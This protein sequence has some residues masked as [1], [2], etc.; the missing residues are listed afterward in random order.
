MIQSFL[1]CTNISFVIK[2]DFISPGPWE[3]PKLNYAVSHPR[4]MCSRG[5]SVSCLTQYLHLYHYILL[6]FREEE[7]SDGTL[8]RDI[9]SVLSY[10]DC[11][12][13]NIICQNCN[14]T[15]NV[16]KYLPNI[17]LQHVVISNRTT[18]FQSKIISVLLIIHL[19][20]PIIFDTTLL[21]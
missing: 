2:R 4:T 13:P 8:C 14:T 15:P 21:S 3:P 7:C 9:V 16:T 19:H 1:F 5:C 18:S 6:I 11:S 10:Q 20:S 12:I 17:F